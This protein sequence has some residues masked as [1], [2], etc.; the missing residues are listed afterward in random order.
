MKILVCPKEQMLILLWFLA[1]YIYIFTAKWHG[2]S[3]GD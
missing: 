2:S 1:G 3:D